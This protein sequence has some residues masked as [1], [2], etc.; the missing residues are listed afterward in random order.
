MFRKIEYKRFEKIYRKL[1][2]YAETDATPHTCK[3]SRMKRTHELQ[4]LNF[5]YKQ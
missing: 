5:F 3:Q 2:D 4:G 1:A